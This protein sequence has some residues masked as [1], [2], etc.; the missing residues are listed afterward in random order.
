M[1][2]DVFCRVIDNFGD[3]GVCGRLCADL[4]ERGHTV[5]LWV[6]DASALTWMVPASQRPPLVQVIRWEAD[7]QEPGDVVIEAFGCNPP[8]AFVARMQRPA[9]PVWINL[10]YLSAE[11]WVERC[12]GLRSPVMSGPGAGLSKWFYYPG[13]TRATGGLLR[14]PAQD[15]A[16][17]SWQADHQVHR[18]RWLTSQG[19]RPPAPGEH[20]LSLFC[21]EAAPV[22]ALL[23]TLALDDQQPTLVLATPGFATGLMRSWQATRPT[24]GHLTL[25]DIPH[26][27]QHDFDRLLWS[28]DLNFVRGEDSAV[29]AL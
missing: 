18:D 16:R 15:N 7:V 11:D 2:W 19:I 13:F 27:G 29:R 3:F 23:D 22:H 24:P 10:E 9:P 21:Y 25:H 26:L 5:R 8:E 14:E 28:C 12:H 20:L 1:P 4:A 17:A 6:D